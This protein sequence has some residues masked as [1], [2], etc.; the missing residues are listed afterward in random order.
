[1]SCKYAYAYECSR[2][3]SLP[4][5]SPGLLLILVWTR[6]FIH[7]LLYWWLVGI[8]FAH[9]P[10]DQAHLYEYSFE[11]KLHHHK[12]DEYLRRYSSN[13]HTSRMRVRDKMAN[14]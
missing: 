11:L 5:L 7:Y 8:N 13:I 6:Q 2:G 3:I 4:K 1:M 9:E 10:N 12:L 14:I